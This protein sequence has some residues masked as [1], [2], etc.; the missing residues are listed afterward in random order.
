MLYEFIEKTRSKTRFPP[1][2]QV[3]V[4]LTVGVFPKLYDACKTGPADR[5]ILKHRGRRTMVEK[6]ITAFVIER[7]TKQ[8][9][10]QV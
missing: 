10:L 9:T 7:A 3:I 1:L 5:K 4:I 6:I 2:I 8:D